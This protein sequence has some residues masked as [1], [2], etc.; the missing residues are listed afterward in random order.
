MLAY[1]F[2]ALIGVPLA[3]ALAVAYAAIAQWLFNTGDYW[4][5]LAT[6]LLR[7]FRWRCFSA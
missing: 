5:P 3:I 1:F 7:S 2:P 4:M 6:P